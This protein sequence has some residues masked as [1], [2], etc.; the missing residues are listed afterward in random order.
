MPTDDQKFQWVLLAAWGKL[1][2][3]FMNYIKYFIFLITLSS[4]GQLGSILSSKPIFESKTLACCA[5]C[6]GSANCRACKTCEYCSWCNSG[7]ACGVCASRT[8]YIGKI[9]GAKKATKKAKNNRINI[10]INEEDG[11]VLLDNK[12]YAC[13]EEIVFGSG[14]NQY[15][16]DNHNESLRFF[17]S[18]NDFKNCMV[19]FKESPIMFGNVYFYLDDNSIITLV[20]RNITDEVDGFTYK[21][22]YLSLD[23]IERIKISNIHR[24]RFTYK[25]FFQENISMTV[26]NNAHFDSQYDGKIISVDKIDFGTL[27]ENL[28]SN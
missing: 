10:Y 6:R 8:P 5:T 22:Y 1:K 3:K 11:I 9:N 21:I 27:L 23:E 24:I 14:E 20:D 16:I 17:L 18:N 19:I 2:K 15:G 7:G 26:E 4:Y 12:S 13:S 25:N 28:M